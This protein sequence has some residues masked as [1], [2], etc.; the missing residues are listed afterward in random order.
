MSS[1]RLIYAVLALSVVAGA[2]ALF[3]ETRAQAQTATVPGTIDSDDLGGAV[4]SSKGPEAGVWVIAETDGPADEVR[5]DRRHRR[6]G[7]LPD[8]RPAQGQLQRVGAWIRAGRFPEGTDDRRQDVEPHR[9]D[10]AERIRRGAVLSGRLLVLAA[11]SAGRER[12]PGHRSRGERHLD[13]TS[14]ARPTGSATSRAA[15]AWR[16]T[17]SAARASAKFPKRSAASRTRSP[18]GIAG[19]SPDRPARA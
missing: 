17:S 12:I 16:A 11:A 10:R 6:S 19:C 3:V 15:A 4:T 1:R 8:A 13:R 9:D 7:P 14:R 2:T 5:E 18:R